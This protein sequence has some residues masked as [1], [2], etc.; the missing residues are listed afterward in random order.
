MKTAHSIKALALLAAGV[1]C[2][3]VAVSAFDGKSAD[4]SGQKPRVV[5]TETTLASGETLPVV[6]V[7]AKKLSTTQKIVLA[8]RDKASAVGKLAA[9]RGA[10]AERS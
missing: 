4:G 7:T 3:A 10:E 5:V 8:M 2:A 6:T 9:G 1:F